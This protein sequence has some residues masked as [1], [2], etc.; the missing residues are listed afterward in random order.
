MQMRFSGIINIL[1]ITSRIISVRTNKRLIGATQETRKRDYYSEEFSIERTKCCEEKISLLKFQESLQINAN[2]R[3]PIVAA[4]VAHRRLFSSTGSSVAGSKRSSCAVKLSALSI[5]TPPLGA[6]GLKTA[7]KKASATFSSPN[8]GSNLHGGTG[9]IYRPLIDLKHIGALIKGPKGDVLQECRRYYAKGRDKPKSKKGTVVINE[10]EIA[11]VIDIDSFRKQLDKLVEEM[12]EDFTKQL[13]IRGAAGALES[14]QV[15]F[16][17]ETYPLQEL[18]QVG[19]KNPQ[20]AVLNLISLPDAIQPV[21][22][23]IKES[24][25]NLSPQQEGTTI[26]VPLPKVTRE[27]RETLAKNAKALFTKYKTSMQGVQNKYVKQCKSQKDMSEDLIFSVQQQVSSSSP[28]SL[29]YNH[30]NPIVS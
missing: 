6:V 14:L 17:G 10:N 13:S 26:Y 11:E 7:C 27:H 12:K 1:P 23:A 2:H 3:M 25:M 19:R 20:L 22:K 16:D 29:S 5:L 4:V 18:A 9:T 8:T 21:L 28:I 30:P 15:E 24:G